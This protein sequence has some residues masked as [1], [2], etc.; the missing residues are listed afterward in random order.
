MEQLEVGIEW[1]EEECWA[2]TEKASVTTMWVRVNKGTSSSPIIRARL[3]ARDFKTKGGES[4]SAAM[5]PLEA[6]KLF[7]RM[8][9]KEQR[10]WRRRRWERRKLMFIDVKKAQLNGMMSLSSNFQMERFGDSSGTV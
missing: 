10:V 1:T 5:P 6:K 2:K 7:Y 8:S 9:A 4:L 3:V